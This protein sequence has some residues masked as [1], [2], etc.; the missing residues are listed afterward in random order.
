MA[1]TDSSAAGKPHPL[2]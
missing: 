2:A 1:R